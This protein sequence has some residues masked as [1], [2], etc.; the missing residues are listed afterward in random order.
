MSSTKISDLPPRMLTVSADTAQ[1]REDLEDMRKFVGRVS[2]DTVL[3]M[4]GRLL[5][6]VE[7][8]EDRVLRR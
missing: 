5:G 6:I 4:M 7:R 8:L 2:T 1:L 3:H